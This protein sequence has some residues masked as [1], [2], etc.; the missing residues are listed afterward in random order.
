MKHPAIHSVPAHQP[1]ANEKRHLLPSYKLF[2]TEEWEIWNL[3]GLPYKHGLGGGGRGFAP[4]LLWGIA[5]RMNT[6]IVFMHCYL[7]FDWCF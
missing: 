1:G 4:I 7:A 3:L 2:K 6:S 5:L